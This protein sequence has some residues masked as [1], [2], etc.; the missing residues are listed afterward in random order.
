MD[1]CVDHLDLDIPSL[2][3]PQH[4]LIL[5]RSVIPVLFIPGIYHLLSPCME[6]C[7][8][9]VLNWIVLG[10]VLILATAYFL[11]TF[12]CPF[13]LLVEYLVAP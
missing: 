2:L 8:K 5:L 13:Q 10:A 4:P 9:T 3:D 6:M 7:F 12:A 11:L 1:R